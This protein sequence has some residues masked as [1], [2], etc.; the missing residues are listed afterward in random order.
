MK[1]RYRMFRRGNVFWCHDSQTGKQESLRT[2]D[3]KEA[4]SSLDVKNR[5]YAVAGFHLQMAQTH[6]RMGDADKIRRTWQ[7]VMNRVIETKTKNTRIRWERAVK[8]RAFDTIRNL[9]IIETKA[10]NFLEVLHK[11]TVAT[12]VY[13][14]RLHNF[15]LD[16]N[17][18]FAPVIPKRAWPSVHFKEKRAITPDEHRRIVERERNPERK[19]FYQICWH[20]G[21]SQS[22]MASLKAENIDWQAHTL[23]YIRMKTGE[24]VHLVIGSELE[25]LLRSLPQSGLLFP[26]LAGVR[27]CD[28]ATEFKQRCQGL[29]IQG[30]TLHS[31]RYSWAQRAKT[32]GYPERYAQQALGH[33]SIAV[34]RAYAQKAEIDL[35]SLED[36]EKTMREKV[37]PLRNVVA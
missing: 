34:H 5:P 2:K 29:G 1:N 22:D 13:L 6:L 12:N 27:E 7:E 24:P 10:E 23:N 15:A 17:W 14:K 32:A 21:G 35:P 4:I 33:S 9:P 18:L 28:R 8:D 19:A 16:M 3:R 30:V 36:Y 20:V 25:K 37:V 11:G 31:Y 26:Y